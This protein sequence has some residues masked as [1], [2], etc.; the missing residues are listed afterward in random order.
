MKIKNSLLIAFLLSPIFGIGLLSQSFTNLERINSLVDSSTQKMFLSLD[1]TSSTFSIEN[2][3]P[4]DYSF[5]NNRVIA[6]LGKSGVKIIEY[7]N[8]P[9][10]ITYMISNAGVEY[11]D[12]F[13]DGLFG[14][15]LIER[16]FQISGDYII[17]KEKGLVNSN[18]FNFTLTDTIRYDEILFVE[19][20]SLPFTKAVP[21]SEPFFPSIVEPV[22]AIT[23]VA[24]TVVLF[25]TVRS[26]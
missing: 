12:L 10:V 13:R 6:G 18:T 16:K 21:P 7:Q 1:D 20:N 22:I 4:D 9:D 15:Y 25:F 8:S 26:K 11:T 3:T 14:E 2:N 19:N 23:A 17:Q 24:I 5:L